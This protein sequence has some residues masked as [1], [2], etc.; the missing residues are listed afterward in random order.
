MKARNTQYTIE[1]NTNQLK[2]V[3]FINSCSKEYRLLLRSFANSTARHR[4][5]LSKSSTSQILH[6]HALAAV[7]LALFMLSSQVNA[8]LEPINVSIQPA[9]FWAV[10]FWIALQEGFFEELG[11]AINYEV[12]TSGAP[13]VAAAADSKAW[14]VGGAGCV[15]NIIGGTQGIQLMAIS[16]DASATSALVGNAAGAS[17]WPPDDPS[18]PV[19]ITPNSTVHYAALKCLDDLYTNYSSSNFVYQPPAE[20]ITSLTEGT[21]DYGSLWAP[22]LYTVLDTVEGSDI[23]CSGDHVGAIVPEGIMVREEYGVRTLNAVV[24]LMLLIPLF[25]FFQ[26]YNIQPLLVPHNPVD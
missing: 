13:Q 14:D 5:M 16:D 25:S 1:D 10:P 7:V 23:L 11:L 6:K 17:A 12:F 9:V 21:L 24:S 22:N 3:L 26:H 4:I 15:P 19:A 18:F 2:N 20:V 8:A